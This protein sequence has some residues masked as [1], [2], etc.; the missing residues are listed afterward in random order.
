VVTEIWRDCYG[1]ILPKLGLEVDRFDISISKMNV[2]E[3]SS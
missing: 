2:L 1:G 3:L